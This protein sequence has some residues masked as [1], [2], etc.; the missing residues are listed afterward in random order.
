MSTAAITSVPRAVTGFW[1]V[2]ALV[3][4]AIIACAVVAPLYG[5]V[6]ATDLLVGP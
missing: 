2:V 6:P 4:A 5:N 3:G 1:I